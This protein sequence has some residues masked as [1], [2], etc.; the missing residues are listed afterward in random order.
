MDSELFIEGYDLIRSDRNR[1]GGGVACYIKKERHYN[2]RSPTCPSNLE[3]IFL[4][5]HL[6]NSKSILIGI[7]YRPPDQSGYLDMLSSAIADMEDF[8]NR[9]VYFLGDLNFNLLNNSKYIL[10]TK[11]TN[12][13]VPWAKK[14]SHFCN[15]HN[16]KQ[17]IRSPTRVAKSC[18]TLLDH[19]LTNANEIGLDIGLSDH[20]L[21]FSQE[22]NQKSLNSINIKQSK[23]EV[24]KSIVQRNYV[25]NSK[26]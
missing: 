15:M 7:L 19:I 8:D 11:Y 3:N 10:D 22:R 20:Q 6:P 21:V 25:T 23:Q 14:Y 4:D 1:H 9:E 12:E 2:V 18:S 17:L 16:L 24:S 13:R 26:M 5:L